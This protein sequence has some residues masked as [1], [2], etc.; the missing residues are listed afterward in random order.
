MKN[1]LWLL[2]VGAILLSAPRESRAQYFYYP[3]GG[4]GGYVWAAEAYTRSMAMIVQSAGL[5]NLRTSEAAINYQDARSKEFD[6]RTKATQSYFENRRM[7]K[8]YRDAERKPPP[9]SEQLYRMAK[10]GIP[11]PLSTNELEPVS[12]EIT[13]PVVLRDNAFASF[14]EL[15][16]QFY[17]GRAAGS[18]DVTY[19]SYVQFHQAIADCQSLLKSRLKEYQAD[20]YIRAKKFLDSLAYEARNS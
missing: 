5:G 20:D 16:E 6:N 17:E 3:Y 4:Y 11:K 12:G 10:Q 18:T 2:V 14:R 15:A 9:T 13:W 7:I 8:S 1:A 19:D